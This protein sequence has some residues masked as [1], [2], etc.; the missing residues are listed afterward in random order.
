MIKKIKNNPAKVFSNSLNS[1]NSRKTTLRVIDYL[2]FEFDKSNH[3]TMKWSLFDYSEILKL[4]RKFIDKNLK[5][6]TI[7]SYISTLKSVSRESWRMNIIDTDTYMRIKDISSIK[8]NSDTAGKALNALDLNRVIN[9]HATDIKNIRDSAVLAIGYGAGLRAFEIAQ[10]DI[11][12][13]TGN[14]IVINGKGQ[15][16]RACYLPEFSLKILNKWL[17]IRGNKSGA[18]FCSL[19]KNHTILDT[20]ISPRTIGDIIDKRC[21]NLR[22]ERFTPHD[23]RRS[24]ATNLLSSGVDV[25]TVQKLMRHANINTTL[26]YDRRGEET[27]KAAIEMLPF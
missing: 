26:I 22:F 13:I 11:K 16:I 25:F 24:F 6:S 9:Y 12:D 10:I 23:L 3:I 5:P 21:E 2:C 18:V 7:N 1:K 14:K 19:T 20:G 8:C 17:R 4:R 27:K 15:I